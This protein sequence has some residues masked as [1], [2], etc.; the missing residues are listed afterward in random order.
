MAAF[1]QDTRVL[2]DS[3]VESLQW[4]SRLFNMLSEF[5]TVVFRIAVSGT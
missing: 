3:K 1:T 4:T 2:M 5:G